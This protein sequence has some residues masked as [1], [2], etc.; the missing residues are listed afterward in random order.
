VRW[1]L[2]GAVA[3]TLIGLIWFAA[4]QRRP[5]ARYAAGARS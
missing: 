4:S 2:L 1:N 3:G 5:A